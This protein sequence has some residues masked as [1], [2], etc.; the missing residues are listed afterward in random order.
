[1]AESSKCSC[2][3]PGPSKCFHRVRQFYNNCS[4]LNSASAGPA[5]YV[6]WVNYLGSWNNR[7]G[8]ASATG[9]TFRESNCPVSVTTDM[10][11][12]CQT[13]GWVTVTAHFLDKA[14]KLEPCIVSTQRAE[15]WPTGENIAMVLTDVQR[16]IVSSKPQR[17]PLTMPIK[18]EE[19][20]LIL[21]LPSVHDSGDFSISSWTVTRIKH[22]I[23]VSD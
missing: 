9:Y 18:Q 12:N 2:R 20:D 13:L 19:D 5:Q 16:F 8:F 4:P 7:S 23:M 17:W 6:G 14:W 21:D 10:S 11:M 22:F 3:V 15:H 1:M